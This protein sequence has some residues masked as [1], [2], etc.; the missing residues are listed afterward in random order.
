METCRII[1]IVCS[2]ILLGIIEIFIKLYE[3]KKKQN[4]LIEFMNN[5]SLLIDKLNKEEDCND[6]VTYVLAK[7]NDVSKIAEESVYNMPILGL[8][9]AIQYHRTNEI[10]DKAGAIDAN[11]IK[12]EESFKNLHNKILK[13]ILNPFTLF[14]NGVE[15]IMRIV[16]GYIISKF[17]SDFDFD[18]NAW[19]YT[20]AIISLLGAIAS[21]L[22]LILSLY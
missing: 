1:I 5:L 22:G 11:F 18:G 17:N 3:I 2:I 15:L 9:S 12:Q 4:T 20:N 19:K 14:Y 7:G 10:F 16:F 21:I 8:K 13:G 6:E